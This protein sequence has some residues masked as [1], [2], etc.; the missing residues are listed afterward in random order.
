MHA[1]ST[2]DLQ[3]ILDIIVRVSRDFEMVLNAKKTKVKIIE[4]SQIL[5]S[6]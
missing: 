3:R 2:H 1:S 5:T 4:K 6:K